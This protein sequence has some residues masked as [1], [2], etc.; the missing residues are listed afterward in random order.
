MTDSTKRAKRGDGRVAFLAR[1]ADFQRLLDAGH[2]IRSI[3]DDHKEELG[4]GY[5]QFTKYVGRFLRKAD[6]DR[7]QTGSGKGQAIAPQVPSPAPAPTAGPTQQ[8]AAGNTGAASAGHA[9]GQ[10]P[11]T[12]ARPGFH[13]NPNSG[14]DRDDL[15]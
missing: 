14:N 11:G 10:R 1:Q 2:L 13:H 3:Y 12:P 6:H 5:P 8:P 9:S 7:H 4:I 15:I